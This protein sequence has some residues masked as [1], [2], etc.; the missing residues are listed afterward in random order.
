MESIL[1]TQRENIFKPKLVIIKSENTDKQAAQI[2]L[3]DVRNELVNPSMGYMQEQDHLD[4][5]NGSYV[6]IKDVIKVFLKWGF[7][8]AL[9]LFTFYF[10]IPN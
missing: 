4:N 10:V 6:I 8:I 1:P 2:H 7:L 5:D 3:D 9:A